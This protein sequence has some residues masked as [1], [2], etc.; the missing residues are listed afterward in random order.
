M[1]SHLIS[2]NNPSTSVLILTN[3]I[4]EET[5]AKDRKV[6]FSRLQS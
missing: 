4:D 2:S 5:E 3:F 1:F 6:N